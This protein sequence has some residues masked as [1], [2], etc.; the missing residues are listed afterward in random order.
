MSDMYREAPRAEKTNVMEVLR[1]KHPEVAAQIQA[2]WGKEDRMLELDEYL[3]KM[4]LLDENSPPDVFPAEDGAMLMHVCIKNWNA[5]VDKG[6]VGKYDGHSFNPNHI[7]VEEVLDA[8][9]N[10]VKVD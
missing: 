6:I 8:A 2:C 3:N 9:G 5:M 1:A 4:L 10:P 7:F